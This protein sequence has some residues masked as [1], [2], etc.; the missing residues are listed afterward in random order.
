MKLGVVHITAY[1][2][3]LYIT[4]SH[5]ERTASCQWNCGSF[6]DRRPAEDEVAY[7]L[8]YRYR[9]NQP[10]VECDDDKEDH[11]VEDCLNAVKRCLS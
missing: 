9:Q 7:S 8:A 4:P 2:G 1:C 10:E 3:A 11:T 5:R 6:N